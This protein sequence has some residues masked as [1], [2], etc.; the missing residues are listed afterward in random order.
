M[1]CYDAA[2]QFIQAVASSSPTPGGGA[3]AAH[4]GALGCALT[5]MAIATTLKKK[6]LSTEKRT[7]LEENLAEFTALKELFTE[8]TR[9][10]A[11]AYES[12]LAVKKMSKDA[13][14]Y[15]LELDDALCESAQVPTTT[16]DTAQKALKELT[17]LRP[18]IAPIIL[19]DAQCAYQ[20]LITCVRL[21]VENIRANVKYIQNT[22]KKILFQQ[23]INEFLTIG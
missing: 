18:D 6:D 19:S 23:K 17:K 2:D 21:S 10:D 12:F 7:R 20:L 15:P 16:A 4:T 9:K 22:D 3:V 13:I 14:A 5:C 8:L 1:N 11:M